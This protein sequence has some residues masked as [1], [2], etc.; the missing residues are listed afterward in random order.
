MPLLTLRRFSLV[1]GIYLLF[2]LAAMV[3]SSMIG[4]EPIHLPRMLAAWWTWRAGPEQTQ[5]P[6]EVFI[7]FELR[8][9]RIL[10]AFVT[11][12]ALAVVGAVFQALLRNPLATPFTLGTASG[13]SFGAA[14]GFFL[15]GYLP[16]VA[17]SWGPIT[18]VQCLSLAGSLLAILMIY[19]LARASGRISTMELLLAGVTLGMIFSSL[20]MALRYFASPHIV[21]DMDRWLM[22]S[23]NVIG[24]RDLLS[25]LPLLVI[26]LGVL[27][28][29]A[30]QLDQ[31]ALGEE[32][33]LGRGVNVPRLQA[34]AFFFG[35]MAV[36]VVV[37]EAGL[38]GFVGL[39]VPHTVRRLS[40]P[41]HRLLL[42]CTL[43]AGG[44]FLV[45]CD[46]VARSLL[47]PTVLPVGIVTSILGG[48]F[49]IYLLVT[50]RGS[51]R[52]WGGDRLG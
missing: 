14:L 20:I 47:S 42:P 7:F 39:I 35:S 10:L 38:I 49:F 1:C 46:T 9:P 15:P 32:M 43:L 11:G 44:G 21:V 28:G 8:L 45:L 23:L 36:G 33:A 24:Y 3:L 12:A 51:K 19:G 4:A 5:A 41:D 18:H 52:V 13:G 17:F 48:P 29:L 50:R 27:L 16:A 6:S 37:A 2:A 22:G 34:L 25:L 26:G 30:R 31:L 40:G